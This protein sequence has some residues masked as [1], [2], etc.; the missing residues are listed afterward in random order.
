MAVKG[1]REIKAK[2]GEIEVIAEGTK[3]GRVRRV[4]AVKRAADKQLDGLL[5]AVDQEEKERAEARKEA[6]DEATRPGKVVFLT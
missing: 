1:T 4:M 6:I 5:K 3:G 2:M